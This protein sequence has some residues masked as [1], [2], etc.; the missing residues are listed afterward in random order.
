M[1]S[2]TVGSHDAAPAV[3]ASHISHVTDYDGNEMNKPSGAV[4]SVVTPIVAALLSLALAFVVVAT[5]R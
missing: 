3:M 2:Y 5:T 4:F 1:H